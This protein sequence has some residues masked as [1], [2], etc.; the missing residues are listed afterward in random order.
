MEERAILKKELF[1]LDEIIIAGTG[2][3]VTPVVQ[4]DKTKIGNGTPGELTR[5]IQNKFF[6]LV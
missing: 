6:G 4:V 1:E 3:E 2:S 5:F